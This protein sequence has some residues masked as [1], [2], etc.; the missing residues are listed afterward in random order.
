MQR[1][2]SSQPASLHSS[3]IVALYGPALIDYILVSW[4]PLCFLCS[5]GTSIT[6]YD[7]RR[8]R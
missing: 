3:C 4:L 1:Y 2:N 5:M 6:N 8:N 7:G